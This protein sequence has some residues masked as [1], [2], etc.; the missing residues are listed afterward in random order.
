MK[1]SG[2]QAGGI[3]GAA[4]ARIED[5]PLVRGRGLFA[6]DV[7]FARQLHMRVV[8]SPLAH[9]RIRRVDAADALAAPGVVAVWTGEDLAD[10][11]PIDF[12]DD[13]V[14]KLVPHRQ[15]VLA[16]GRVRYVGEPMAVVFADDPYA[17][18][19]AADHVVI[20]LDELPP[21]MSADDD[22][23]EIDGLSTEPM[24]IE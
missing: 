4:V 16:R 18:E 20:E 22:P 12:R 10:I 7:S 1:Q 6:A 13:R 15:P 19:D 23:V 9:A 17:A 2:Q 3:V 5:P 21:V 14:E 8:R 11:S 24:I